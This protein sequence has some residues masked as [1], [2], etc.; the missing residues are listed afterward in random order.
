MQFLHLKLHSEWHMQ[1]LH[2]FP[3]VSAISLAGL[4]LNGEYR[5]F[6]NGRPVQG[7][8]AAAREARTKPLMISLLTILGVSYSMHKLLRLLAER[9]RQQQQ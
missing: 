9:H 2:S 3:M 5:E 8:T 4:S 7:P 1:N 6:S